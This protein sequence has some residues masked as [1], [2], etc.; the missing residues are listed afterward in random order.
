MQFPEHFT[1]FFRS[2]SQFSSRVFAHG[3][4][5]DEKIIWLR[6]AVKKDARL[7]G[8]TMKILFLFFDCKYSVSVITRNS[9]GC[10]RWSR[11]EPSAHH[12]QKIFAAQLNTARF[13]RRNFSSFTVGKSVSS[14]FVSHIYSAFAGKI[15]KSQHC[16]SI[17][18]WRDSFKTLCCDLLCWK[19]LKIGRHLVVKLC[20]VV[21]VEARI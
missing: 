15:I 10:V 14:P 9:N 2:L 7:V 21:E 16:E 13:K 1:Q 3:C 17:K 20:I 4:W 5:D 12:C 19:R 11:A 6:T 8:K 18:L